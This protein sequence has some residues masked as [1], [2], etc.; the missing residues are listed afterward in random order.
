V[1]A[2]VHRW[3][4][5]VL[6]ILL[7]AWTVTGL[8][9]HLKPGWDGAYDRLSIERRSGGL[10][11]EAL[12]TTLPGVP[13]DKLEYFN[14][15]IGPLYRLQTADGLQLFDAVTGAK[16]SPLDETA[17]KTLALDAVSRSSFKGRYG[18]V[19]SVESDKDTVYVRFRGGAVVE[20]DRTVASV[21]QHGGDTGRIDWLYRVHYL[22]WTGNATV[23][24]GIVVAGLL[25]VWAVMIPGIVLFV[26][27]M[28]RR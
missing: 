15:A 9:F 22:Q 18:E 25:L 2:R 19:A 8:L 14:T 10:A 21:Y 27:A 20:V 4:A 3:L 7:V 13:F 5:I 16:R 26:R 17:C 6:V 28:R 11:R 1:W 12:A 23:D 24:K